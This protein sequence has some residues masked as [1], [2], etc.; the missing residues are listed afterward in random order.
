MGRKA[1]L[2]DS[3]AGWPSVGRVVEAVWFDSR[4]AEELATLNS[5]TITVPAQEHVPAIAVSN[6]VAPRNK[7]ASWSRLA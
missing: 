7:T 6:N 3:P 5:E 4:G 1:R 2:A